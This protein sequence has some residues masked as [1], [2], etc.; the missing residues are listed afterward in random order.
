MTT[1]EAQR[2]EATFG[3]RT[4]PSDRS[5]QIIAAAYDLLQE[6]GVEG[7]TLRAVLK[8]TGL[9]RRAFYERFPG[10]DDLV[11]AVFDHTLR[12]LSQHIASRAEEL[13]D[14]LRTIE[15]FVFDLMLGVLLVGSEAVDRRS[16]VLSREH[17]RLAE[18]RPGDLQS[19]LRPMLDILAEQIRLGIR[20]GQLRECDPDLQAAFI[21]SLA[22]T[23]IHTELLLHHGDHP[24]VEHR[25]RLA[26]ETWEF[27]RRAIIA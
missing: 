12:L 20:Q 6:H 16:A 8:R 24:D 7:L 4:G 27:C 17:L 26:A 21:Y 10:K 15:A 2:S 11:L 14:P 23:T 1:E 3:E 25:R 9:A 19:A 13:R 5:H 22:S 18:A